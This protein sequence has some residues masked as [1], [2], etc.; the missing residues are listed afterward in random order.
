[1]MNNL[2]LHLQDFHTQRSQNIAL[3]GLTQPAKG[4]CVVVSSHY[5]YSLCKPMQHR[6]ATKA[7]VDYMQIRMTLVQDG[8]QYVPFIKRL[9]K[10]RNA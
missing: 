9:I 2:I 7:V 10:E 6:V 1:M 8:K 4:F 5:I 3:S